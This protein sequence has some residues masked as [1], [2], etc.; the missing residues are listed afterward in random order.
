[1]VLMATATVTL[2]CPSCGQS[3][4]AV[5]APAPPTQWFPCPQCRTPVPVV[6]PRDPPPLYSW[7]VLPGLYPALPRPRVTRWR[8]RR[9]TAGALIAIVVLAAVFAGL[10]A[11]YAAAAPGPANYSVSGTVY[12]ERGGSVSPAVGAL[13]QL[14]KDGGA[15]VS[16]FTG[17][18]GV[19]SFSD[20]P[21]G[22]ITLTAHLAGFDTATVT[23]FASPVYNAG[24]TGISL[25][26]APQGSGNSTEASLSPFA[27]LESLL[28]S[29]GTGIVLLGI[30]GAVALI[31]AVITVRQDRPA[32]GVVGGGAGL[33]APLALYL[34]ALGV[35]FPA[36]L[37][38]TSL[39]AALGAFTLALRAVEIG[40]TGPAPGPD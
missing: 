1:M 40:Q 14:T 2:R 24:T 38:A 5:V 32:V 19:F 4:R 7:E 31:A 18:G 33:A 39:L 6:V 35:P 27:D 23:T 3:L 9:A 25:T 20:V 12:E 11:Y 15:V 8:A 30:V 36:V 28:A 16:V 17:P 21:T 34:L 37:A 29:I 10:L 22:G 26:L 13:V